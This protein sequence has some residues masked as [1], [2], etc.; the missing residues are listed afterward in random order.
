MKRIYLCT[1]AALLSTASAQ[2]PSTAPEQIKAMQ[3][4]SFLAGQWSGE[5]WI[6]FGPGQRSTFHEAE[7]I[8]PKLGGLLLLIQGV[9]KDATGRT[10]HAAL[11]VLS[12]DAED[13]QYHFRAY[14]QMGHSIDSLAECKNNTL[15]WSLAAGPTTIRYTISLNAKGQW[16]ETGTATLNGAAEQQTFEMTL[17][18]ASG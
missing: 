10:V 14:E 15:S 16:H 4:C 17:D 9:G 7:I 6:A 5:G 2:P 8:E 11:T 1:A 3:A 12:F 13:K 18:K